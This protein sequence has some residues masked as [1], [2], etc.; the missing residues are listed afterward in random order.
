MTSASSEC[1]YLDTSALVKRYVKEPGSEVVDAI[2]TKAYRGITIITTSYWNIAEVVVVFDKYE[3]RFGLSAP[4]LMEALLRESRTLAG[5]LRLKM[6]PVSPTLIH[7]TA[8][9][10]LKHHVY[11]ADALQIASARHAN[12]KHLVTADKRLA[13]VAAAEDLEAVTVGVEA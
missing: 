8:E 4:H 2:Y 7:E 12:C 3:R 10:V 1:Y 11:S 6:I 9:L 5:L 13:N